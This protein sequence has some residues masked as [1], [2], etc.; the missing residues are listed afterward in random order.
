MRLRELNTVRLLG[1][2]TRYTKSTKVSTD[3]FV[4]FVYLFLLRAE[5]E[6]DDVF[7]VA[8]VEPRTG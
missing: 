5:L 3:H 1:R 7:A 2:K 6:R 8:G 4:L